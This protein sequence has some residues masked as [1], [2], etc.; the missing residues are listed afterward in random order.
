MKRFILGF[1]VAALMCSFAVDGYAQKKK[2]RI[3][4]VQVDKVIMEPLTQTMPVLGRFV[5][6]ESGV[7][8]ALTRGPVESVLVA[9]GDR[10]KKGDVIAHLVAT[11]IKAARALQAALVSERKA[12]GRTAKAQ[13]SLTQTELK[14]LASLRESVAFSRARHDDKISEVAKFDSE[15]GEKKAA[16]ASA[17]AQL[18]LADID[19]YNA[20]IRAPYNGVVSQKHTSPGAFLN[21]GD[22]VVTLINDD[23]LEI[24]A[25]VP[26]DRLSGL[27]I[28]RV[29]SAKLENGQALKVTVR[30]IVPEENG[31]TRTRPVRFTPKISASAEESVAANQ[32]VTVLLPVGVRRDVVSVHKDAVIP[33][34]GESIVFVA[35]EG[36]AVRQALQLGDAVGNRFEVLDGLKAGDVVVVRGNERL[37]PGQSIKYKGM[38]PVKAL[39]TEVPE[40]AGS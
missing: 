39:E 16:I 17:R 23:F 38:K 11:R 22:P 10:V 12:Q 1:C 32:S 21:V 35:K 36:K 33:R 25:D 24:E 29:T 34:G 31:L 19:L 15:V 40:K 37:R 8:A 13:L 30:A 28:G 9:V 2:K 18:R 14:R 4:G 6:R 3:A 7:V 27:S 20:K 26:S 5:A